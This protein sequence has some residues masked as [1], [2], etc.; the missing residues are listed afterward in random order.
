MIFEYP[1]KDIRTSHK[2][3]FETDEGHVALHLRG[4]VYLGGRHFTSRVIDP[5]GTVWY[6]DGQMGYACQMEGHLEQMNSPSLKECK[7]RKLVLAVYAQG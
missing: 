6:H 1:D 3:H 4:I 5:D 7:G 2:I